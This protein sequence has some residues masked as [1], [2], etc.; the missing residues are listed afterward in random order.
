MK[1]N[2][3][4]SE[5]SATTVELTFYD[6]FQTTTTKKDGA[7]WNTGLLSQMSFEHWTASS[8]TRIFLFEHVTWL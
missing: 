5:F 2:I 7:P 6:V 8:T 4:K 1:E 3:D